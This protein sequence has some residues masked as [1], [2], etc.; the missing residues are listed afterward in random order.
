MA[1]LAEMDAQAQD[2]DRHLWF[3]RL[4]MAKDLASKWSSKVK[5]WKI[6]DIDPE[7]AAFFNFKNE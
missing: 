1:V 6:E 3:I 5:R 7:L 2:H 4:G